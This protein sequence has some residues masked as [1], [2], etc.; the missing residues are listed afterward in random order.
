MGALVQ[1]HR[2]ALIDYPA[3]QLGKSGVFAAYAAHGCVVLN[4]AADGPDADGLQ[5]GRHYLRL[6]AR[7]PQALEPG[8]A[9]AI[10]STARTWYAGHTLE[11]QAAELLGLLGAGVPQARP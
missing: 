4:T 9:Q 3:P 11:R 2:Y 8:A 1:R 6:G 10:A 7:G 5:Q